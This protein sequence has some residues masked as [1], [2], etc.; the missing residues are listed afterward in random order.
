MIDYMTI[1]KFA[2]KIGKTEKPN[3]Q[4]AEERVLDMYISGTFPYRHV[5]VDEGQDFGRDEIEEVNLLQTIHDA[6]VDNDKVEGTFY[7]FYDRLQLVQ[8]SHIPKYISEADCKLTLYRNCRN[9]ENIAITSLKPISERTPKLYDGAIKGVPARIHFRETPEEAVEIVGHAVGGVCPFAVK[10]G[11]KTC[12]DVSLQRF[13]TVFPACGSSNSA[14][15]LTCEELY[16]LSE[17]LAWVDVCK[18]WQDAE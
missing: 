3:Y 9:T 14:I 8:S 7:V 4:I 17:A 16:E 1:D 5:I 10:P 2:C 13:T 11:V 6:V 15:E 18:D 12:L